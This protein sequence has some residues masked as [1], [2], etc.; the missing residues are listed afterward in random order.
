[1]RSRLSGSNRT[2]RPVSRIASHGPFVSGTGIGRVWRSALVSIGWGTGVGGIFRVAWRSIGRESGVGG[3]CRVAWVSIARRTGVGGLS[4]VVWVS[5]ARS[6]VARISVSRGTVGW[7]AVICARW[8]WWCTSDSRNYPRCPSDRC[9]EGGSRP[10][11]CRCSDGSTRSRSPKAPA[12]AAF[13]R[14]IGVCA[15]REAQR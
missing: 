8:G 2:R 5:V 1:M 12:K 3:V 4:R 10:T 7:V 13:D 9:S 15:G 14:I 6:C 11:T